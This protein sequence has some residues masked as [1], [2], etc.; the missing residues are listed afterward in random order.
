MVRHRPVPFGRRLAQSHRGPVQGVLGH[1]LGERSSGRS[2]DGRRALLQRLSS[3]WSTVRR[4][5]TTLAIFDE[6]GRAA[7]STEDSLQILARHWAPVFAQKGLRDLSISELLQPCTTHVPEVDWVIDFDS[8]CTIAANARDSSPGP[9]GVPCSAWR[10]A[11][12]DVIDAICAAHVAWVQGSPLPY[13]FNVS[14]TVFLAKGEEPLDA[15][16]LSRRAGG[17]RPLTLSNTVA[18]LFAS[19]AKCRSCPG[20]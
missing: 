5:V 2:F 3:A 1:G 12:E 17:T 19:A 9:D 11:G 8:F 20:R 4:R 10:C 18:K 14:V 16:G 15:V 7:D 6:D 13:D